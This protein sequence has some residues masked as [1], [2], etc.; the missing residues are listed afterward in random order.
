MDQINLL[1][2]SPF[3]SFLGVE[4]HGLHGL[5]A[6]RGSLELLLGC[7]ISI[8]DLEN[9]ASVADGPS[10]KF[11]NDLVAGSTVWEPGKADATALVVCVTKN[12]VGHDAISGEDVL[13][14]L[15]GLAKDCR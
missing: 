2:F 11:G 14:S 13:H 5:L 15:Q 8:A 6:S 10:V 12:P 7:S 3:L 4:E 9:V 1:P